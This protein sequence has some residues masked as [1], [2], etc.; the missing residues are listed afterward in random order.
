MPGIDRFCEDLDARTEELRES[1]LFKT[2]R[3]IAT[4]QDGEVTL[5]GGERVI[6]LCANNYLGLSDNPKLVEAARRALED[7]GQDKQLTQN[8]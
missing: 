1:G 8:L 3:V 7:W 2:E 4:P 6:N 5:A